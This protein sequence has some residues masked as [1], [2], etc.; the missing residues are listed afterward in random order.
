MQFSPSTSGFV[1][2][3]LYVFD[4]GA[5]CQQ[6]LREPGE[7]LPISLP[8]A[9]LVGLIVLIPSSVR[10]G[11]SFTFPEFPSQV[12]SQITQCQCWMEAITWN[13]DII[14]RFTSVLQSMR[15]L[16]ENF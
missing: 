2:F 9:F 7:H 14:C 1:D 11:V 4:L 16:A 13:S 6:G 8:A 3:D 5:L 10:H 12:Q 15:I